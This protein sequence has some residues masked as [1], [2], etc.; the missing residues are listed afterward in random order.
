[1]AGNDEY[2]ASTPRSG[3]AADSGVP[4]KLWYIGIG[5]STF[6]ILAGLA[7]MVWLDRLFSIGALGVCVGFGISLAVFG[8]R[9]GGL[10]LKFN[11]VGGGALAIALYL[12][13][14]IYPAQ[15]LIYIKY[16]DGEIYRTG[17]LDDVRGRA[18]DTFITGRTTR[19]GNFRFV[20]FENEIGDGY[21]KFN[22]VFSQDHKPRELFFNCISAGYFRDAIK[23]GGNLSLEL[24]QIDADTFRL[25]DT[26][27]GKEIGRMNEFQCGETVSYVG[28]GKEIGIASW[29][30]LAANAQDMKSDEI[31]RAI[32][33]LESDQS[34]QRYFAREQLGSLQEPNEFRIVTES[35]NVNESSY[36]ADLG[37]LVAWSEAIFRDRAAAVTLAESLSSYQMEYLVQLTGQGDI[38]MRQLATE[39]LHRLLETTSWPNGP[40]A[41]HAEGIV[42][43]ILAVVDTVEGPVPIEK[44]SM[45]F[46]N[47]DRLYNTIVAIEFAECNVGKIYRAQLVRALAALRSQAG[48]ANDRP[49]TT[50]RIDK[51]VNIL[52]ACQ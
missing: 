12:L 46:S 35:W 18:K 49:R 6:L 5:F 24:D 30:S 51:V 25:I 50:A 44:A 15:T 34:D 4:E 47:N 9:I 17:H 13:L 10:F 45:E 39:V 36:R 19:G 48:F 16:L 43:A 7:V 31:L 28:A 1:M 42:G 14:V 38:T 52:M 22:F 29:L 21:I 23:R 41:E 11:V 37:R 26:A 40:S 20:V 8:T 2:E 32:E 3:A 27:R 33:L